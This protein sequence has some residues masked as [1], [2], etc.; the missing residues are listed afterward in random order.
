MGV[1]L[2]EILKIT[3]NNLVSTLLFTHA[4]LHGTLSLKIK[5][6]II[7]VNLLTILFRDG[8][9][10]GIYRPFKL[11]FTIYIEDRVILCTVISALRKRK[12]SHHGYRVTG[13]NIS[14]IYQKFSTVLPLSLFPYSSCCS[15]VLIWQ[16]CLQF[17]TA[18]VCYQI[19]HTGH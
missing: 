2:H 5:E 4:S 15:V 3:K 17:Q 16:Y 13:A 18:V 6:N 1:L 11:F 10:F 14:Q 12:N 9:S 8:L 7:L 19:I